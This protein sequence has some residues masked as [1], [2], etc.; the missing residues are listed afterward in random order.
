MY[1]SLTRTTTQSS[2]ARRRLKRSL[3]GKG[4]P[5]WSVAPS[6]NAR[7][8]NK[9]ETK[10]ASGFTGVLR[11]CSPPASDQTTPEELRHHLFDT[12]T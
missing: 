11:C 4:V 8:E 6:W 7:R 12:T 3:N 10:G 2:S 5:V 1:S 9:T